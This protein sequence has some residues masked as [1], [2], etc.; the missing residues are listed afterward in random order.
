VVA[1]IAAAGCGKKDDPNLVKVH[2]RVLQNGKPLTPT[3]DEMNIR[4]MLSPV[5][6]KPGAFV[7]MG[8]VKPDTGEFTI[9]RPGG[10]GREEGLMPGKYLFS[11][12]TDLNADSPKGDRFAGKF[13]SPK[14]QIIVDVGNE[15]L[16]KFVIDIGS[17]SVTKE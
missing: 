10:T 7:G 1:A 15:P 6:N 17:R 16:Q 11:L 3:P 8:L 5:E 12:R 14:Q 4:L 13:D 2:G 9:V